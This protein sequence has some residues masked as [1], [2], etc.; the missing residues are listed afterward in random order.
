MHKTPALVIN[1]KEVKLSHVRSSKKGARVDGARIHLEGLG[2]V[3]VQLYSAKDLAVAHMKSPA[4]TPKTPAPTG[5][6]EMMLEVLKAQ[7]ERIAEDE[8]RIGALERMLQPPTI[9]PSKGKV[10]HPKPSA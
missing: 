3:Y 2:T 6:L 9:V 5:P 1:G 4:P 7:T 8:R 10:P